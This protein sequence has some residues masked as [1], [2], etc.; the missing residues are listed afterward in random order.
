MDVERIQRDCFTK[1]DVMRTSFQPAKATKFCRKHSLPALW[2]LLAFLYMCIRLLQFAKQKQLCM[3]ICE[4][5][6][7]GGV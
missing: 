2:V 3:H 7:K 5:F 4:T 6:K 1:Y